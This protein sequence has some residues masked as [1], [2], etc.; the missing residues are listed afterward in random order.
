[1]SRQFRFFLLPSDIESLVAELRTRVGVRVIAK[2]SPTAKIV[3][4][5]T[6]V[7]NRLIRLQA[8]TS[9]QCYL[10]RDNDADIRMSFYPTRSE[11]LIQTESEVVEFSGCDFDGKLLT[12]GRFYFQNDFLAGD[13]IAPKRKEFLDW[14]DRVFRISKKFLRRSKT[15]DAYVGKEADRWKE[16]GG[17]FIW[18]RKANG[19]P[20]Y[21]DE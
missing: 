11:W 2:A 18:M 1:M 4:I 14:A 12:N 17:R 20:M 19:E 8:A 9:V 21:A 16:A 15:L 7:Q 6:P 13:M 10:A 3:E 5:D